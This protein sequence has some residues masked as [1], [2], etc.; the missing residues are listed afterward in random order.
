MLMNHLCCGMELR[1]ADTEHF[2]PPSM[3]FNSLE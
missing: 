2:V 1:V 3:Q